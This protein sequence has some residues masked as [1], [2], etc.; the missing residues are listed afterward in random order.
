MHAI[1]DINTDPFQEVAWAGKQVLVASSNAKTT[2]HLTSFLSGEGMT[3]RHARSEVETEQL[4]EQEKFQL[5]VI[6]TELE[7]ESLDLAHRIKLKSTDDF[8]PLLVITDRLDDLY[9]A[10]CFDAGADDLVTKPYSEM[11]L[12][13]RINALLKIGS[14][15]CKEKKERKELAYYHSMMKEEQRLAKNI[16][17][18]IVHQDQL[19][20]QTIQYT[21]SPMSIFNGDVLLSASTPNGHEYILLGDFTGHGLTA[22]IGTLP[23]SEI[24]YA[25]TAKGF[26]LSTIIGEINRRL[27]AL[28]P[29]GMFMATY[30]IDVNRFENTIS[31]WGG[32]IPDLLVRR[33]ENASVE[34]YR[35]KN[36]PIGVIE[37]NELDLDMEIIPVQPGDRFYIYT[38]GVTETENETGDMFGAD[39]LL[40]VI[41]NTAEK[42]NIF[43]HVMSSLEQFRAGFEQ[44]DDITLL[45]Y[46]YRPERPNHLLDFSKI[47]SQS[48]Q[49]ASEWDVD[50]HFDCSTIKNYDPRPLLADYIVNIQG[51][52]EYRSKLY[53]I[54]SEMYSNALDHGLLGLYALTSAEDGVK[55]GYA[56]ERRTRL[57]ELD[58][59]YIN[60]RLKNV[61]TGADKGYISITVEDSGDGFD[62]H[63]KMSVLTDDAHSG[64][65]LLQKLADKIEYNDK[66]NVVTA[67]C[68]WSLS[69]A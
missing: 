20:Q 55:A 22:S 49:I 51:L 10:S 37:S 39:A 12:F 44:S 52:F 69:T 18:S 5:L 28:L 41:A 50:M 4:F 56:D 3:V 32:G 38:D 34:R 60:I 24:F 61:L 6:D 45:E 7:G 48:A 26:M 68:H 40:D 23:V 14:I 8:V 29:I 35:A 19:D 64:I 21:L 30:A 46:T 43:E 59:G 11:L 67:H 58:D 27:R 17:S 25:M 63:S 65:K 42:H 47:S 54:L 31:V 9:M 13:V 66:G 15:Y 2:L 33:A 36:L 53:T 57:A 62:H 1:A 16:F